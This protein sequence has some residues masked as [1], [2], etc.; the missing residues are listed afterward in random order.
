MTD[1]IDFEAMAEAILRCD[2]DIV[3]LNEMRGKGKDAEYTAQVERLAALTGMKH[4][5]FAPAITFPKKGPYGNGFISKIPILNAETIIIPDP[6]PKKHNGYYET[7]C[8]LKVILEGGITVL[9]THFGL[10]S[11][12]A[13]KRRKNAYRQYR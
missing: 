13:G 9:V 6:K 10:K 8:V 4:F 5:Y 1:K 7:R 2:A 11:R 3:G 12:R